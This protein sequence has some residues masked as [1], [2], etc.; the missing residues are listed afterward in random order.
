MCAESQ[1]EEDDGYDP[2]KPPSASRHRWLKLLLEYEIPPHTHAAHM[3]WVYSYDSW[4]DAENYAGKAALAWEEFRT[5][6]RS[7]W[8]V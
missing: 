4:R 8:V 1:N 5:G 2:A 3:I 7:S 6:I